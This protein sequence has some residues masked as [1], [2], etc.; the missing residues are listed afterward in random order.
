V[1]NAAP[2][3]GQERLTVKY[4]YRAPPGDSG[5]RVVDKSN[6]HPFDLLATKES[7]KRFIEVKGT[8]GDGCSIILTYGEV[9]HVRHN[10]K[11]SAL[12]IVL[13]IQISNKNGSYSTSGGIVSTH[14]DPSP[15]LRF[16]KIITTGQI[17]RR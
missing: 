4:L 10:R 1:E 8:T 17:L 11:N 16:G 9:G 6:A 3:Q 14:E 5:W 2:C 12:V 15:F 7:E 13:G